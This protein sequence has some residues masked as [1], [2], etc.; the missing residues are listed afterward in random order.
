MKRIA[1]CLSSFALIAGCAAVEEAD[2]A[3]T[4]DT[5]IH[6]GDCNQ[7]DYTVET[8]TAVFGRKQGKEFLGYSAMGTDGYDKF[9]FSSFLLADETEPLPAGS[10]VLDAADGTDAEPMVRAYRD[11]DDA[12]ENCNE[13]YQATGVLVIESSGVVGETFRARLDNVNFEEMEDDGSEP[14]R[15]GTSFCGSNVRWDSAIETNVLGECVAEGE[16]TARGDKVRDLTLKNCYGD[17]VAVHDNCGHVKAQVMVLTAS[18]CSACRTRLPQ[19]EQLITQ[20]K[21]QGQPVEAYYVLGNGNTR[22]APPTLQECFGDAQAK[23]IDPARVLL[24]DGNGRAG[25]NETMR[26]GWA[27]MCD[28]GLPNYIVLD[29]DDMSHNFASRC[30]DDPRAQTGYTAAIDELLD[31]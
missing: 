10:Y 29:G 28:S 17:M 11:C 8:G 7:A 13:I 26:R 21:E 24:D 27:D 4:W 25:F 6:D 9:E 14:K 16:G 19:T 23:S 22:G 1:V 18:W 15:R 30:G 12:G 2:P 5:I 20:Y 31:D 3:Q